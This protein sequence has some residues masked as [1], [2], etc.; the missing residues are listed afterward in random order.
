[1]TQPVQIID[2]P[3]RHTI[4]LLARRPEPSVAVV[5]GDRGVGLLTGSCV[6]VLTWEQMG[7]I[8]AGLAQTLDAN[9]DIS[10]LT[11]GR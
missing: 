9:G 5:V 2:H 4:R 1:M 7:E 10:K 8:V 3:G 11:G 6:H